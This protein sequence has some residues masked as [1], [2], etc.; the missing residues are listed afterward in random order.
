MENLS[1]DNILSGTEFAINLKKKSYPL[2]C[3]I[4]YDYHI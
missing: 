4:L 1:S 3:I 2:V